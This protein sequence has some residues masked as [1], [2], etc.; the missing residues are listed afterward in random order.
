MSNWRQT[1]KEYVASPEG[2]A[3]ARRAQW[4]KTKPWRG[5][6]S[7]TRMNH[8]AKGYDLSGLTGAALTKK[9][10][11]TENCPICG[12]QLNWSPE[13][14]QRGKLAMDAPTL[15]RI[16]NETTLTADNVWILCRRCNESKGT[17]RFEEFVRYC[18]NVAASFAQWLSENPGD[19][20][21][22]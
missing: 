7:R 8:K 4:M 21:P 1:R 15:D 18:A 14:R 17:M 19:P 11:E 10:E 2:T 16:Y 3:E 9:A 12:V 13:A 5:W 22:E 6:T 20:D